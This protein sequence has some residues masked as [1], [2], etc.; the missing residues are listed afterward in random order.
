MVPAAQGATPLR[1]T[2]PSHN[3]RNQFHDSGTRTLAASP[4]VRIPC[5]LM[6]AQP[7]TL[8]SPPSNHHRALET[9]RHP[10]LNPFISS[11][12]NPS[13]IRRAILRR[14]QS[15]NRVYNIRVSHMPPLHCLTK[16]GYN[17][18]IR[19]STRTSPPTPTSP[20][21]ALHLFSIISLSTCP[22]D[23]LR[24]PRLVIPRTVASASKAL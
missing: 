16:P 17:A 7:S 3:E 23:R 5:G 4:I 13:T 15:C 20:Y 10:A 18:L 14:Q 12:R 24:A 2:M 9:H 1:L 22:L 21:V 19:S 8:P 11:L 6:D